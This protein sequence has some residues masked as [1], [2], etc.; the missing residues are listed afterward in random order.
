VRNHRGARIAKVQRTSN[1]AIA[2]THPSRHAVKHEPAQ[3]RA[4]CHGRVE[5]DQHP[6]RRERVANRAVKRRLGVKVMDVVQR[7]EATTAPVR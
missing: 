6:A 2:E 5:I 3:P 7:H 1:R 4:V